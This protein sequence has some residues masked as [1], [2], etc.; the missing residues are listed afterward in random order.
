M[1]YSK[2]N[3][4]LESI[5]HLR[6]VNHEP[7]E[8]IDSET[9][10]NNHYNDELFSKDSILQSIES[11]ITSNRLSIH[12]LEESSESMY[13]TIYAILVGVMVVILVGLMSGLR[14]R[15]EKAY[16]F[17]VAFILFS[18]V[19]YLFYLYNWMYVRDG[20]QKLR[21]RLMIGK[22]EVKTPNLNPLPQQ[23]Y[24][25]DLCRKKKAAM[26]PKVVSSTP[27]EEEEEEP[28]RFITSSAFRK[29]LPD[30][31]DVLFYNDGDAPKL[32]QYPTKTP[33]TN[34]GMIYYPDDDSTKRGVYGEIHK[35]IQL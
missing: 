11:K 30:N 24:V 26:N 3:P 15:S 12:E 35:T 22:I 1:E 14:S 19:L 6:T 4:I 31:R 33:E 20:I 21:N 23:L 18:Y 9:T 29:S 32:L 5:L 34:Y 16:I 7:F 13:K 25:E 8:N 17:S 10:I 27:S 2:S 28:S